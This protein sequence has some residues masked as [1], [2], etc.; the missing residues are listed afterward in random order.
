ME[1]G[2][3]LVDSLNFRKCS[4]GNM[5]TFEQSSDKDVNKN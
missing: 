1:T 5:K 4:V 3:V 2:K